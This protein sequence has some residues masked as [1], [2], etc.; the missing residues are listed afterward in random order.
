[1]RAE[2]E[3]LLEHLRARDVAGA[4]ACVRHQIESSRD[5]IQ[6][7]VLDGRIDLSVA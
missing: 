2:H 3:E 7:A 6:R 1:M 4:V 5:R